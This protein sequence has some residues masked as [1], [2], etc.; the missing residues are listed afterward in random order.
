ML[1]LIITIIAISALIL[2]HEWGHFFAA[3][4]L[5]VRVEEFGFGFPPRI[6][7]RVKNR[8]RYSLNLFLFGGFVRIFGEHG[9]GKHD[10]AS[11]VS[12]PAWQR[13][14]ILI[15]GVALNFASAWILF[16]VA[17][18]IRVQVSIAKSHPQ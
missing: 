18:S 8:V 17:A 9:E 13:L 5:G 6:V 15:A 3:R 12:R 7:S 16:T 1:A 4:R 2:V 11:F 14:I 10:P